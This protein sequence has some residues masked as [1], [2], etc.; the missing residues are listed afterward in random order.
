MTLTLAT[1]ISATVIGAGFLILGTGTPFSGAT[2]LAGSAFGAGF[3]AIYVLP[4]L[5]LTLWSAQRL[6]PAVISF[7]LTAEILSGVFSGVLLLD[8]PFG[9]MQMAGACLIFMAALSEVLAGLRPAK[10]A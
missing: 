3:G 5:A 2:S 1:A 4:I 7:L 6:S 9:P 10:A 8:E